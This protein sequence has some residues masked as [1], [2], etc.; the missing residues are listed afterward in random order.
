MIDDAATIRPIRS[1]ET[2]AAL[3]LQ[4][5]PEHV[6]PTRQHGLRRDL[7]QV[8]KGSPHRFTHFHDVKISGSNRVGVMSKDFQQ[9]AA[10]PAAVY[11]ADALRAY[12]QLS[13]SSE[14]A[15]AGSVAR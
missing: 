1:H 4:T 11:G 3:R 10:G 13:A 5:D 9:I 2:L 6:A 7:A 14:P 12:D 15:R 8:N